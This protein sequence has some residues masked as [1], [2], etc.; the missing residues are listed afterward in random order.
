MYKSLH[1]AKFLK[2]KNTIKKGNPQS[3]NGDVRNNGKRLDEQF[4]KVRTEM[5]GLWAFITRSDVGFDITIYM[6]ILKCR[7]IQEH[8]CCLTIYFLYKL[9]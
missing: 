8:L 6:N 5:S 9:H 2:K 7:K 4:S 3:S 1:T